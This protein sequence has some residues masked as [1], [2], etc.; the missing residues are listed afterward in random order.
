M[1]NLELIN[2]ADASYRLFKK[3]INCLNQRCEQFN[4]V[5][6]T[7]HQTNDL[8]KDDFN[9]NFGAIPVMMRARIDEI[10]ESIKEKLKDAYSVVRETQVKMTTK[11]NDLNTLVDQINALK[12]KLIHKNNRSFP[13]SSQHFSFNQTWVIQIY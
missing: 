10:L 1:T 4:D 2:S 7:I 8:I 13:N 11:V 12:K 5:K 3:N 9:S 6:K